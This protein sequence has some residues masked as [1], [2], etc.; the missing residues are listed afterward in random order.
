MSAE[1]PTPTP[2]LRTLTPSER[3]KVRS[4]LEAVFDEALGMYLEGATDQS[5]GLKLG[6]PWKLVADYR[7]VAFGPIRENEETA[8]I[9]GD[10]AALTVTLTEM[11]RRYAADIREV[12][13]QMVRLNERLTETRS[14][15]GLK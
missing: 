5:I 9:S 15:M 4:A 3:T 2:T 13:T 12:K 6:L 11:E 14:K 8:K 10:L 1:T 7:E